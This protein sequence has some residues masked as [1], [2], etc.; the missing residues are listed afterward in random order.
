MSFAELFLIQS[1]IPRM[2]SVCIL[3]DFFF[4]TVRAPTAVDLLSLRCKFGQYTPADLRRVGCYRRIE[5]RVRASWFAVVVVFLSFIALPLVST[6]KLPGRNLWEDKT[7]F[8]VVVREGTHENH[9]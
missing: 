4:F 7:L 3:A 5:P 6:K 2:L 1:I 8:S 9:P